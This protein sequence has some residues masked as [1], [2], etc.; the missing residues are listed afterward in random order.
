[1]PTRT[2]WVPLRV[3][4]NF[5][6]MKKLSKDLSAVASALKQSEALVVGKAARVRRK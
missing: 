6:K 1:R 2:G 5:H 3:I 4:C